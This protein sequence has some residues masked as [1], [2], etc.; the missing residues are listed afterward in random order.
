MSERGPVSLGLTL[1]GLALGVF[2]LTFVVAVAYLA[3]D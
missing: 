3:L 2:G 1:F